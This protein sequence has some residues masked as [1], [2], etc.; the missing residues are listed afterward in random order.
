M[1]SPVNYT[2]YLQTRGAPMFPRNTNP[3]E[4]EMTILPYPSQYTNR[5]KNQ[6][7]AQNQGNSRPQPN[8][9]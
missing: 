1:I 8:N 9:F 5:N 6:G 3:Q 2:P 4:Q 7:A